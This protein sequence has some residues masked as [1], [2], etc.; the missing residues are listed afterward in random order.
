VNYQVLRRSAVSLLNADCG[1]DRHAG[2]YDQLLDND[3]F[4]TKSHNCRN[5]SKKRA[6]E[7]YVI[8]M[9][10][11]G[12]HDP[13]ADLQAME[14]RNIIVRFTDTASLCQLKDVLYQIR[15]NI[16]HGEKAPGV[17]NDDR[18]VKAATPVLRQLLDILLKQE[19]QAPQE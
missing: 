8:N 7:S 14:S 5:R 13:S 2:T 6:G 18:I 12:Q 15:C 1:V 17:R 10:K 4:P 9:A 19:S 11:A 3:A 16:F